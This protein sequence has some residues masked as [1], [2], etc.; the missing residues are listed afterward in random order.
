[1]VIIVDNAS[2]DRTGEVAR[3]MKARVIIESRK[4]KG[5]ALRTG[6]KA[7]PA[8]TDYVV[9]IDGDNT[10]KAD[11]IPRLIEPVASGF[12]DMI[13]GSRLSGKITKG[14]LSFEHKLA[15]WMY[16]FL[17]RHFYRVNT[18]DVLSGF[19]VMK[20]KLVDELLPNLESGGFAIEMEMNTKASRMGYGIFSVP[21]TYD[22]REGKSKIEGF[23]DAFGIL[24]AFFKYK[25]W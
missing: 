17:V 4:G 13:V 8:D 3:Q 16:T 20:K 24:I 21:I 18:T 7:I 9:V 2:S 11:E 23:K 25:F 19:L 22:I 5:Y 6:F 10:Y 14:S 12:A 1:L 15:N